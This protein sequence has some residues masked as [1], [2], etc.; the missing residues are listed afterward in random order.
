VGLPLAMLHMPRGSLVGAIVR[1]GQVIIP[2]GS[3]VVRERDRVVLFARPDLI[4]RLQRLLA[5]G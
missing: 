2:D 4:P 1:D 5:P 3:T